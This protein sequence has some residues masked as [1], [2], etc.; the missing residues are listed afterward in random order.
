MPSTSQFPRASEPEIIILTILQTK[1]LET[2]GEKAAWPRSQNCSLQAGV[3]LPPAFQPRRCVSAAPHSGPGRR[4]G[5]PS[6][7]HA[8]RRAQS[9]KG[10]CTRAQW[11]ARVLGLRPEELRRRADRG[12]LDPP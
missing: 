11:F 8:N 9:F 7:A 4:R 10:Q 6:A 2:R 3:G 1:K 5:S 12:A